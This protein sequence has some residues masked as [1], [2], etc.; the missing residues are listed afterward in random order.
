MMRLNEEDLGVQND[1]D[2]IVTLHEEDM[3]LFEWFMDGFL[4]AGVMTMVIPTLKLGVKALANYRTVPI[5]K[6]FI[7]H[8]SCITR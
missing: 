5:G 7:F 2:P 8:L 6:S 1:V 3:N 4:I